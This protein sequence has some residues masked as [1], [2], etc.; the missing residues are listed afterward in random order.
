MPYSIF[1]QGQQQPNQQYPVLPGIN[2]PNNATMSGNQ[3]LQALF[4]LMPQQSEQT[5][6]PVAKAPQGPQSQGMGLFDSKQTG[7]ELGQFLLHNGLPKDE[8][9]PMTPLLELIG[10][11]KVGSAASQ[12]PQAAPEAAQE[13][14]FANTLAQLQALMTQQAQPLDTES[15]IADALGGI[16]SAYG[17]Q[18]GAL[19]H[20][21]QGARQDTKKGTKEIQAMYRALAKDMQKSGKQ[22]AKQGANLAHQLQAL[23]E[24][25]AGAVTQSA[26]DILSAN[27]AGAGALESP[28]ILAALNADTNKQS[29]QL[30]GGAVDR[31][32]LQATNQLGMSG[33]NRR[34]FNEAAGSSKLEG[35]NRSADLISSLQ[36]YL[37]GNRDKMAEIAGQKA[38]AIAAAKNSILSQ[39]SQS[40]GD[41]QQQ[42]I[43]NLMDL[44]KFNL[45]KKQWDAEFG[46]KE[47]AA[48]PSPGGDI[49][50][51]LSKGV[52][53]ALGLIGSDPQLQNLFQQVGGSDQFKLGYA[54]EGHNAQVPLQNNY[55]GVQGLLQELA[56]QGQIQLPTDPQRLTALINA[57]MQVAPPS[58]QTS[59]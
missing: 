50:Q 30:A 52:G 49:S 47:Q 6:A 14:E 39:A 31:A 29:T 4:A 51:Y 38:Q 33:V 23:G 21:N 16:K 56:R 25:G 11:S 8:P 35:T 41:Q 44:A 54:D 15:M 27:A 45:G 26:S 40:Q 37:Q 12:M 46:L 2:I 34:Y 17:A 58:Q 59:Y 5:N 53:N 19:K 13:D 28:E 3:L 48:A 18:I 24:Q 42:L 20:Q 7:L 57:L 1:N 22:E 10:A 55:F 43:D 32:N 9:L 36:D